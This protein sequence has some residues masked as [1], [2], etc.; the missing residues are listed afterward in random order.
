MKPGNLIK[1]LFVQPSNSHKV[2]SN[3]DIKQTN[4]SIAFNNLFASPERK[5]AKQRQ[6]ELQFHEEQ[7]KASFE[8]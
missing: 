6:H 3:S 8:D 7:M 4:V 5:A 1:N 2:K